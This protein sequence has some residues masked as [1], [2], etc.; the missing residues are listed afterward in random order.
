MRVELDCSDADEKEKTDLRNW[1]H[2]FMLVNQS[3][4]VE[5]V[6]RNS[7]RCKKL[8][9]SALSLNLLV[10]KLQSDKKFVDAFWSDECSL[11]FV[12]LSIDM[13]SCELEFK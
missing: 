6:V 8:I 13:N 7:V 11:Q 10:S 1:N 5:W 12:E 2:D 3:V 4:Y 9:W